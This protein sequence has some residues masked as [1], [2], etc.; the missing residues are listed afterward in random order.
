MIQVESVV[1]LHG[2]LQS[3][4]ERLKAQ[5]VSKLSDSIMD[6]RGTRDMQGRAVDAAFAV[7]YFLGFPFLVLGREAHVSFF[8][9]GLAT[10]IGDDP[11]EY[12]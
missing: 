5:T 1:Q 11:T 12:C 7:A 4:L 3:E 2:H 8:P 10:R 9:K 6:G